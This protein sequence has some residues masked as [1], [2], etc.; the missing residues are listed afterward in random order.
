MSLRDVRQSIASRRL[1]EGPGA[2]IPLM[3]CKLKDA[4]RCVAERS[5][6]G[7]D[8]PTKFIIDHLPGAEIGVLLKDLSDEGRDGLTC[9]QTP[10]THT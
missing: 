7:V 2:I 1:N 8:A 4:V 6:E 5:D 9:R 3:L 10:C